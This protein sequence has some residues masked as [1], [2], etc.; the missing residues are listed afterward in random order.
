MG[1]RNTFNYKGFDLSFFLNI[2]NGGKDGYL[3]YNEK[4]S[5][6]S[7]STGNASNLN[8]FDCYDYWSPSN[9][10]AKFGIAW[11]SPAMDADILQSR[12][13]V[14]LQDL[15]L[16]YTFSQKTLQKAKIDALRVF[17]SGKNL[18]TFTGWDGWD[19]EMGLGISST[20]Y[21]VMKTYA[22]GVEITF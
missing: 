17:F 13:F 6:V 4:P 2:I 9:T 16:G 21:P 18:L 7:H 14:R 11:N 10:D 22:L 19:P 8:W 3:A 15:S 12:S 1:I 20:S 5:Y